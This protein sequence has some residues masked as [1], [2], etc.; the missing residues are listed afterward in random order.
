MQVRERKAGMLLALSLL[1]LSCKSSTESDITVAQNNYAHSRS[2]WSPDGRQIAFTGRVAGEFG[3]HRA[4]TSGGIPTRVHTGE[5]TAVQWSPD[6]QWLVF[7]AGGHLYKIKHN[8]D[9]LG[10]LS[11]FPTGIRPSWSPDGRWIAFVRDGIHLLD[12]QSDSISLLTLDG[13]Y[14]SWHPNGRELVVM[15]D[16]IVSSNPTA[17]QYRFIAIDISTRAERFLISFNS[18]GDAAY[19]SINP[20]ADEIVY[21]VLEP[22]QYAEVWKVNVLTGAVTKLTSEGGDH[23][24][25]S[26]DGR[27]IA[28]TRTYKDDGGLWLMN[29]DGSSKRRL[30]R[31]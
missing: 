24:A 9:S 16:L 28:F 31:P 1:L 10:R 8:G 20:G 3:L 22:L 21:S 23:P 25:W 18:S 27:T 11:R 6:A 5:G 13:D 29:G 7:W 15:R 30:T 2:R 14:P 4:D 19:S 26:P 12:L 17:Y